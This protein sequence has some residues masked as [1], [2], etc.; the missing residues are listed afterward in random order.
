MSLEIKI[1]NSCASVLNSVRQSGLNFAIQETPFSF[2]VTVRKSALRGHHQLL[3]HHQ[4]GASLDPNIVIEQLQKQCAFL[5]QANDKLQLDFAESVD[6]ADELESLIKSSKETNKILEEK[7]VKAEAS[8]LKSYEQSKHDILTLKN[9]NKNL[10]T[11]LESL[12]RDQNLKIKTIRDKNKELQKLEVKCDN[13]E[14]NMRNLKVELKSLKT[15]N[16]KF[17][18]QK[19]PR[20]SKPNTKIAPEPIS[21]S[22]TAK[23][24][25]EKIYL[26]ANSNQKSVNEEKYDDIASSFP[27]LV[28]H[29][30]P[31]SQAP[32]SSSTSMIIH[33]PSPVT[34]PP[35]ISPA[36]SSSRIPP[37]TPPSTNPACAL[38]RTPAATTPPTTS[39]ACPSPRTPPGTP[40]PLASGLTTSQGTGL[41]ADDIKTLKQMLS[42]ISQEFSDITKGMS[43]K[44][45]HD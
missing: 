24:S 20:N 43:A 37:G 23:S 28:S 15:E 4:H 36:C 21:K 5:Q 19:H 25:S 16:S 44:F 14:S 32:L 22:S 34:T 40:P 17:S 11:E 12:K 13:L 39:A 27:S 7:V 9:V 29:W 31:P 42:V 26:D 6:Y 8:A 30:M 2:Y 10:N 35:P 45:E 41:H 3:P 33:W 1:Q 18:R 38:P